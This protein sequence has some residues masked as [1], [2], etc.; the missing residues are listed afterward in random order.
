MAE[1]AQ[2]IVGRVLDVIAGPPPRFRPPVAGRR[3]SF[4]PGLA[5]RAFL[6]ALVLGALAPATTGLVMLSGLADD[7]V[8]LGAADD[9]YFFGFVPL[10]MTLV[11]VML[12][13]NHYP[14]RDVAAYHR[15]MSAA[16]LGIGV[17][18]LIELRA[19]GARVTDGQW[20]DA[21]LFVHGSL[22]LHVLL[23]Y[24]LL[25]LAGRNLAA[26]HARHAFAGS[27]AG[28]LVDEDPDA[29][30]PDHTPRYRAT[31][32]LGSGAVLWGVLIST[33]SGAAAGTLEMPVLGTLIGGYLGAIYGLVPTVLGAIAV[34]TVVAWRRDTQPAAVR[35]AVNATLALVGGGVLAGLWP[36]LHSAGIRASGWHTADLVHMWLVIAP[37]VIL[38][39]RQCAPGLARHYIDHTRSAAAIRTPRR[40]GS[41][42]PRQ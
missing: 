30:L 31:L 32:A 14:L 17:L 29:R 18:V 35:R 7:G 27:G 6:W 5:L 42:S 1:D 11:V 10:V 15:E 37:V 3:P 34:V 41:F 38:L 33:I 4:G 36:F 12:S 26:H 2:E 8:T 16:L 13:W 25:R 20:Q 39:L 9:G 40:S 24:W 21:W 23:T 28:H 19:H 22:V